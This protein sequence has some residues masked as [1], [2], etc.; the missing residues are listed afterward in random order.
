VAQNTKAPGAE[1]TPKALDQEG[2]SKE[3]WRIQW[4]D[5]SRSSNWQRIRQGEQQ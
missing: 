3:G 2:A 1:P 4:S 5:H